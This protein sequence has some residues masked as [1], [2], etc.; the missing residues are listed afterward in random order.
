VSFK[1]TNGWKEL[2]IN[3]LSS[4]ICIQFQDL[5][6]LA[7]LVM[8]SVILVFSFLCIL[9]PSTTPLSCVFPSNYI[10]INPFGLIIPSPIL[11]ISKVVHSSFLDFFHFFFQISLYLQILNFNFIESPSLLIFYLVLISFSGNWYFFF[12]YKS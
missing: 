12:H 3:L 4:S 9:L 10:N 5:L 7:P 2:P 11:Q 8:N 6:F 1:I